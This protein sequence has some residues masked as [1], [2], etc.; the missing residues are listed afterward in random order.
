MLPSRGSAR[1]Y[2]CRGNE[3]TVTQRA[4]NEANVFVGDNRTR[5]SKIR[6]NLLSDR[7]D[8]R[9]RDGTEE[10]K[11]EKI[12]VGCSFKRRTRWKSMARAWN[13]ATNARKC[14]NDRG[15][16]KTMVLLTTRDS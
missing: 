7:N 10:K 14:V 15:E 16:R 9:V 12:H 3:P 5:D 2:F 8:V 1:K 6:Q 4:T 13:D 11:M